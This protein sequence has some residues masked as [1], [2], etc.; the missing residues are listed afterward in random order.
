MSHTAAKS[1]L[2][3]CPHARGYLLGM[4]YGGT[5]R[6][7]KAG[8]ESPHGIPLATRGERS[9][10][11][12]LA[13]CTEARASERRCLVCDDSPRLWWHAKRADERHVSLTKVRRMASL[14][15]QWHRHWGH[16]A[17]GFPGAKQAEASTPGIY[18][19]SQAGRQRDTIA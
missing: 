9:P 12:I 19:G 8:G 2:V 7:R 14:P 11:K 6:S 15:V 1:T 3:R 10:S 13:S 16:N 17:Y 5:A 18:A 4:C